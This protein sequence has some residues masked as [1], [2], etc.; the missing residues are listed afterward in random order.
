MST[1]VDL[2]QLTADLTQLTARHRDLICA[3]RAEGATLRAIAVASVSH[4]Q[5]QNILTRHHD[6]DIRDPSADIDLYEKLVAGEPPHANPFQYVATPDPR[7]EQSFLID[8]SDY[9][10]DAWGLEPHEMVVPIVGNARG[11]MQFRH[12]LMGF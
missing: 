11:W 12:I 9:G 4:Q 8:P 1:A 10:L 6:D 5:V 2:T 3:M 7:N